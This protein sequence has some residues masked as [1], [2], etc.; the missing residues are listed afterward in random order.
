MYRGILLPYSSDDDTID[1]IYGVINWKEAATAE[2]IIRAATRSRRRAGGLPHHREHVPV[3]ADG[4]AADE[5]GLD[6][7]FPDWNG[8][9]ELVLDA[10]YA[11]ANA[12]IAM[13]DEASPGRTRP[14]RLVACS[15][16]QRQSRS[17]NRRAQPRCIY[18]A[19]GRAYDFSLA[20]E[21]FPEDY[22]ELLVD[23]WLT[24]QQRAPMTP[25]VKAD[26][27]AAMT[28]PG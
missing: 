17:R 21:R 6:A 15:A 19:I 4:P 27:G 8:E 5:L 14:C 10:S 3:W 7:A 22:A 28:R 25:V 18:R 11:D 12:E 9:D 13:V 1:F 23:S 2:L 26:F 24:V 20:A 16:Q